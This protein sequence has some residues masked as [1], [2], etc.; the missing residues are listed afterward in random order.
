MLDY[1]NGENLQLFEERKTKGLLP[2]NA[3]IGNGIAIHATRLEEEW[4][5]DNFYNWTDGCVAVKY[6]EMKD[7]YN[8]ISVGTTVKIQQ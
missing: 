5:V 4:T 1:P 2:K 6:S 8:F 7:L 3:S